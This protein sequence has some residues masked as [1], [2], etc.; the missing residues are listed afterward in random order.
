[1]INSIFNLRLRQVRPVITVLCLLIIAIGC[2]TAQQKFPIQ[3]KHSITKQVVD[4]Q[5]TDIN[6][7]TMPLHSIIPSDRNYIIS[8]MASWC[9]PC[10]TELSAFQQVAEEWKCDL[11]TEVIAISIEKP[12]DTYKLA[13]LVKKQNWS[14]QVVHDKMSYTGRELGVFDIPQTFLVNQDKEIVYT[15]KGY[16]SGLISDYEAEIKKLMHSN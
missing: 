1:L 14:M 6:G 15:T 10:R 3:S 9:G 4:I 11:N 7:S 8:I 2:A 5:V 16:H 12:G 13:N